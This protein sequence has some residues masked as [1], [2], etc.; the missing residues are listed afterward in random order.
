MVS[1]DKFYHFGFPNARGLQIQI[2]R[3][4]KSLLRVC[5]MFSNTFGGPV[6]PVEGYVST[7]YCHYL[8]PRIV[9]GLC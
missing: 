3:F 7:S 6:V 2:E 8:C 5:L 1:R 4:V 9:V